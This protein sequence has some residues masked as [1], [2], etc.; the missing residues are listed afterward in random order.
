M[1]VD[2]A[3]WCARHGRRFVGGHI[4]PIEQPV[5]L[6]CWE[7]QAHRVEEI[8]HLRHETPGETYR[9]EIKHPVHVFV[10][11]QDM[12]HERERLADGVVHRVGRRRW[13]EGG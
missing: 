9:R 1:M 8:F 3:V 7:G 5:A 10:D 13:S 2:T 4:S 12:L 11:L 6:E